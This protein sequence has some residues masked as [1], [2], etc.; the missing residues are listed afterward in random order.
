MW[1]SR[2]QI[3]HQ[4]HQNEVLVQNLKVRKEIETDM[5]LAF[6]HEYL[7]HEITYLQMLPILVVV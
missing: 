4:R 6:T 3:Q 1:A 5:T 7:I 2:Q